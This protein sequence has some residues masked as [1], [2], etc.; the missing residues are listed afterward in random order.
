MLRGAKAGPLQYTTKRVHRTATPLSAPR[1]CF[2]FRRE[3]APRGAERGPPVEGS[4]LAPGRSH[5]KGMRAA[6]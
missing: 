1:S 5:Q 6:G 4:R 2:V 3:A